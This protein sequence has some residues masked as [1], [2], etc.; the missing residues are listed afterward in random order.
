M[1]NGTVLKYQGQRYK[2]G[3][4]RA[5]INRDS[6]CCKCQLVNSNIHKQTK[7]K[8][9]VVFT[10]SL[11][12]QK[13]QEQASFRGRWIQDGIEFLSPSLQPSISELLSLLGLQNGAFSPKQ[14]KGCRQLWTHTSGCLPKKKKKIPL[15]FH[16][17]E[18]KQ[19]E[20]NLMCPLSGKSVCV[21]VLLLIAHLEPNSCSGGEMSLKRKGNGGLGRQ[22][23]KV[24]QYKPYDSFSGIRVHSF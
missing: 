2:V 13:G 12:G 6:F 15:W 10:G 19:T 8:G 18:E 3:E 21:G 24:N 14:E 4:G 16:S 11:K 20:K 5:Y 9:G 23:S 22:R 7:K 17:K 1:R